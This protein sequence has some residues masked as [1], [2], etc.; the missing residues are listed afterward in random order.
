MGQ[1]KLITGIVMSALFVLAIVVFSIQFGIDN[2]SAILLGDD[3]EYAN[4]QSSIVGDVQQFNEDANTSSNTLLSTTQ[5][6]GDQSASSGGQFKVTA[7]TAMT[8]VGTFLGVSFT[9]IFGQD[10]GFGIFLT[11]IGSI[12]LWIIGLYIWKTWKGNPD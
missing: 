2:D 11:A 12:L 5:E 4:I 1:V 6:A 9:K 3:P 8:L 7:T 10:T